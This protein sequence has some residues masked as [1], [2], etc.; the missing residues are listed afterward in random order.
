MEIYQ[1][2]PKCSTTLI[3]QS[4]EVEYP[5]K[6]KS[7]TAREKHKEKTLQENPEILFIDY[8]QQI[9]GRK[10]NNILFFTDSIYIWKDTLCNNYTHVSS[11]GIGSGG[12]LKICKDEH[13][14]KD[15]PLL[16]ITYYTKGKVMIQGNEANLESF[17]E[18]F[19]LLKAE[20]ATKKT[21]ISS[22]SE[23]ESPEENPTNFS[24]SAPPTQ[25]GFFRVERY[26]LNAAAPPARQLNY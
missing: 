1:L 15:D 23:D 5:A 10:K 6:C 4:R 3:T 13:L 17:E 9:G 2:A 14:D 26:C 18:A 20:V 25:A 11:E 24:I 22:D 12:R 19:P 16:T 21:N 7:G 8:V